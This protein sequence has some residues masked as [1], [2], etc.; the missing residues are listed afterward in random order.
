MF[1]CKCLEST[2]GDSDLVILEQ[3]GSRG[4]PFLDIAQVGNTGVNL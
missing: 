3:V 1:D 2:P 4:L